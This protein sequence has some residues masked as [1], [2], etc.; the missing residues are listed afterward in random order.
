MPDEGGAVSGVLGRQIFLL[1]LRLLF[2]NSYRVSDA[3][4]R[5]LIVG[6]GTAGAM[7]VSELQRHFAVRKK[8]PVGFVDD[9]PLPWGPGA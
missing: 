4:S 5:V 6:A 2:R 3:V 8:L 9:E 7:V 1:A